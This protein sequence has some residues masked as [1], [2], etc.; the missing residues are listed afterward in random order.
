MESTFTKI[1][2]PISSEKNDNIPKKDEVEDKNASKVTKQNPSSKH[3]S[4]PSVV[5]YFLIALVLITI[6]VII[7]LFVLK[8]SKDTLSNTRKELEMLRRNETVL[9]TKVNAYEEQIRRLKASEAASQQQ[10]QIAKQMYEHQF[11]EQK[12]LPTENDYDDIPEYEPNVKRKPDPRVE[13]KKQIKE[14]VNRKRETVAD[15]Q[16]VTEARRE[17]IRKEQEERIQAEL[18]AKTQ[19]NSYKDEKTK[20][21][22]FGAVT[23][24]GALLDDD[25]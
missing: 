10:N 11:H 7:I 17:Q 24:G 4:F 9:K 15:I 3:S 6:V 16:A 19:S 22:I 2:D 1:E 13:D 23:N 12:L 20:E 8:P 25:D 18:E 21:A 14:M 5:K